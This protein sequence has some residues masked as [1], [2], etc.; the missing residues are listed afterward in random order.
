MRTP[1]DDPRYQA[2]NGRP[3]RPYPH[4]PEPSTLDDGR[5]R[6]LYLM[7]KRS[8]VLEV[9]EELFAPLPGPKGYP[10]RLVLLGLVCA[11]YEK[12]STNLDD[13]FEAITFGT[14][15]RLRA[16]LSIPTCDIE[17]QDA[18]NALY[19]RFHRAWSRLV[20]L[21]D[22]APHERR[23]RLPRAKGRKIAAVWNGPGGAPPL[24]R[25]E[26]LANRLV[27]TPVRTAFAKRLMRHWNGDVALDTTSLPSWAKPHTRK[28]SSLEPS[29]N[30]HYKGGGGREFGY[31]LTMAI[32]AH[33][34][35]AS[36]GRYPQLI[37]G[38]VL[39]TPEK[40]MGRHAWY[41]SSVLSQFTHLRGFAAAD[42]AY[43]K[44]RPK[45]FHQPM[46]D[47]GFMPV[48]DFSKT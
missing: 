14:S 3:R 13:G 28:R 48:L 17:D 45:N 26:E 35:P 42:R 39:H 12:A 46:R 40:D 23:S 15:E 30:W 38:M 11:C 7:L 22:A 21:L 9:A 5:V 44:L 16:E 4:S 20:R 34:D 10:I 19:N 8:G 25:L 24:R 32:T 43:T 27:T 6:K 36:A 1:A 33:A 37:L 41:V 18:V 47:L 2:G 31:S 29:A